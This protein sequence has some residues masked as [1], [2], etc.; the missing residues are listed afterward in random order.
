MYLKTLQSRKL[1]NF[2]SCTFIKTDHHVSCLFLFSITDMT[3]EEGNAVSRG[4][5]YVWSRT[6][7]MLHSW[8]LYLTSEVREAGIALSLLYMTVLG[9]DNITYAYCLDQCVSESLPRRN[10]GTFS[11]IWNCRFVTPTSIDT[12]VSF[13]I[14]EIHLLEY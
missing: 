1:I 4:W 11:H 12:C 5:Q 10:G 8:K 6:K 2:T 13:T 9:F 14:R 7:L 3:T